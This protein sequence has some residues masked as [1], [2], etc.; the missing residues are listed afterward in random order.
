[1]N[2]QVGLTSPGYIGADVCHLNL[3]KTFCIP[4]GGGGP[5]MGPIG[6]KAHLAPFM[7]TNAVIPTGALP[8]PSSQKPFG[9]VAAA[10][11]GSALILPI[12]YAYIALMGAD[13]LTDASKYAI[14]NANYMA[15]RLESHYPILF[16][17][18]NGT[19]A[20]EFIL[21]LRPIKESCGIESEDVAKRLMDY[22]YHA[23]TMSWPVAGTLMVEPTESE[24]QAEMDRFCNAMIAIRDEIR[25]VESGAM[26]A[27]NNPLVN[28]PHPATMV[29]GEE[30]DKPYSR[31]TAAFPAQW[32]RQ[33]KFWPTTA[34]VDN[35]FGDRNLVVTN[36]PMIAPAHEEAA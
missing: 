34:R 31:E 5:G 6:V 33:S 29:M 15:K 21:D 19:C 27:D 26:P 23:P 11:W 4:H 24:S 12:S 28:A 14:L 2:A 35:V 10:P 30:W 16:R 22:G 3:H 13:G 36:P 1:M 7:P 8:K 20:H 25:Q 32:V 9:A 17:G 18:K